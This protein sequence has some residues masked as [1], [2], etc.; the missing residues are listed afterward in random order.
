MKDYFQRMSSQ[1]IWEAS[2]V[3]FQGLAIRIT[4]AK[5]RE[6]NKKHKELEAELKKEEAQ[7]KQNP[8]ATQLKQKILYS[9]PSTYDLNPFWEDVHTSESS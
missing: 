3:V 4:V 1:T 2:K 7:L 6:R 9:G 5:K 8:T